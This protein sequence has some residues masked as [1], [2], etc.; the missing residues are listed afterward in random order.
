MSRD[1][2]APLVLTLFA[3]LVLI[4]EST[5]ARKLVPVDPPA[6]VSIEVA[7]NTYDYF[8][9]SPEAPL[10]FEVEGPVVFEAITRWR[11]EDATA[12]VDVEITLAV[13][14]APP[15]HHIFRARA[16]PSRYPALA[17]AA[18]GRPERVE[19]ELASGVHVV[20]MRLV[21]PAEGVLDVNALSRKPEVLPWQVEWEGAFGTSYDTNLYRYS[22]SDVD[23]FLDGRREGR[24]AS[25]TIDDVRL[26]P[27]ADLRLVR[28][29]PGRRSTSLA[30]GA[31]WRIPVVNPDKSFARLSI[32]LREER[33]GVAFLSARYALIPSYHIRELWDEDDSAYRSCDFVKH[34]F[35]LEAGSARSLPVDLAGFL[36]YEDYGYGP[37]FIEY[38]GDALTT[39]VRGVVRPVPGLRVDL[40]Y[41]LRRF[42]A[43]GADEIGEGRLSSDDSDTTY[44]QDEYDLRARWEAGKWWRRPAVVYFRATLKRRFYLT[45]KSGADDPYHAG[46]EDTYWILGARAA[47]RLTEASSLEAFVEQRGRAAE[48]PHVSDIGEAKDYTALRV[49][50]RVTVEGVRI[51][52]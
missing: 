45:E 43:R 42:E 23:D 5:P 4:P 44:D 39:G 34:G 16:G 25:E 24:F 28:E 48:S 19:T 15:T 13:D 31:D 3:F 50:L 10:V 41:A 46:R 18:A 2:T 51:L 40:S 49:G 36:K 11:F 37:G 26:E 9:L 14:G 27:G 17:G 8:P 6:A 35:R 12:P 21:Q 20:E 52:D 47:L 38:D 32:G 33:T 29:E 1:R 7:G 22:D 30:L